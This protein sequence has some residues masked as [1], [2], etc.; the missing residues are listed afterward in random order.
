MYPMSPRTLHPSHHACEAISQVDKESKMEYEEKDCIS[1]YE[2]LDM[3]KHTIR[4]ITHVPNMSHK[5]QTL[6]TRH[7]CRF[8]PKCKI[9][10]THVAMDANQ[11]DMCP[12]RDKLFILDGIHHLN[13]SYSILYEYSPP[14]TWIHYC[15]INLNTFPFQHLS[16]NCPTSSI[17]LKPS[18]VYKNIPFMNL[19][20]DW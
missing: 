6:A 15:Y 5:I 2:T 16:T 13:I 7:K 11:E 4:S 20:S 8:G 3:P 9:Y 14:I 18:N 17:R 1:K 12:M 10:P 19:R